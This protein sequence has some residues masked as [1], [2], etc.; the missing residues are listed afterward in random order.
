MQTLWYLL[1]PSPCRNEELNY[2]AE[3]L[4]VVP[5]VP[6]CC[7]SRSTIQTLTMYQQTNRPQQAASCKGVNGILQ[8]TIFGKGSL[9]TL[10]FIV[11]CANIFSY[12]DF[13]IS[14]Y[15]YIIFAMLLETFSEY[16]VLRN[17]FLTPLGDQVHTSLQLGRII[18]S[19]FLFQC[20]SPPLL[21]TTLDTQLVI[22]AA[23]GAGKGWVKVKHET[24]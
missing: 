1:N 23:G 18:T 12:I 22:S 20:H 21:T 7:R 9:N 2:V 10:I 5:H 19:L 11:H 17:S 13:V 3:E 14:L 16:F 24:M 6:C 15:R 4:S 8:N